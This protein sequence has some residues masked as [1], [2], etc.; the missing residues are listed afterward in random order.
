MSTY[1]IDPDVRRIARRFAGSSS[2]FPK[3]VQAVVRA[4]GNIL[5]AVQ[6]SLPDTK[7]VEDALDVTSRSAVHAMSDYLMAHDPQGFIE[8]WAK[9]WAPQGATNDPTS[10]NRNW[11]VN[12]LSLWLGYQKDAGNPVVTP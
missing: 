1:P 9:T 12:V 2:T 11:P 7:T 4:E 5:K 6:C 10:L 8:F 3:L